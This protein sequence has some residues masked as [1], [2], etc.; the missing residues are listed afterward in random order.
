MFASVMLM[1]ASPN[2]LT[3]SVRGAFGGTGSDTGT[4]LI[5]P[6]K[7][8]LRLCSG[9]QQ[10]TLLFASQTVAGLPVVTQRWR[11]RIGFVPPCERSY[12]IKMS[13]AVRTGVTPFELSTFDWLN[14]KSMFVVPWGSC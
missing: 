7:F 10:G 6:S 1:A 11:P 2:V 3:L 4:V 12:L 8:P 9:P 13:P 5:E 14:S